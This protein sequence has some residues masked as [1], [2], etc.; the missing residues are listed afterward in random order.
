MARRN[1]TKRTQVLVVDDHP[2]VRRG[3]RETINADAGFMVC[4]EAEDREGALAAIAAKPPDLVIVDLEL[5]GSN[6][7]ELIKEIRARHPETLILVLSVHDEAVFAE[8]TVRA[9]ASGYLSKQE[10]A[11]KVIDALR[12]ILGG[13]IYWTD[14]V[15]SQVASRLTCPKRIASNCPLDRLSER[16]LEVFELIG[17]GVSTARIAKTLHIDPSTVE[18]HRARIKEKMNLKDASE[19]LQ[20]A[21]R[22]NLT[23]VTGVAAAMERAF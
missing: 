12:R 11:E 8:R 1:Q 5:K 18:T 17:N 9:G 2:L 7:L 15:A 21:I 16:E 6:G 3:L 4:G 13:Q 23:R 14:K 20:A 10:A 22:W 19:L